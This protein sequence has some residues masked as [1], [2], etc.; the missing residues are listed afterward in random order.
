MI[1]EDRVLDRHLISRRISSRET[2]MSEFMITAP[3]LELVAREPQ[4]I[5]A[6]RVAVARV[7][8]VADAVAEMIAKS[9]RAD[10]RR[11]A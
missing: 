6:V 9:L 3:A 7:L 10:T 11:Q 8:D 5:E 2:N 4:R 1:D